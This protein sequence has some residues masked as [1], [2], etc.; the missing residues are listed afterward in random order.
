VITL[1][2]TAAT[3]LEVTPDRHLNALHLKGKTRRRKRKFK[4]FAARERRHQ[5][6][7]NIVTVL[8]TIVLSSFSSPLKPRF[9]YG[10]VGSAAGAPRHASVGRRGARVNWVRAVQLAGL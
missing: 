10:G 6:D 3:F 5:E 1:T 9:W 2:R 8:T 4:V 7:I